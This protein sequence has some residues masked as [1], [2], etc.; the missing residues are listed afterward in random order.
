MKNIYLDSSATVPVY[1]EVIEAMLPFLTKNYGNPSS[2]HVMGEIASKAVSGARREISSELGC[3]A[4][5]IVFTSG[6][7]E[8]NC[9]AFMGLLNKSKKKK[10]VVSSIEHSSIR[11]ACY[12][13]KNEGCE[14]IEI[15]V[16]KEGFVNYK[17]LEEIIDGKTA[18]VSVIHG[19]NEIGTLQD[20][21][22]IAKICESKGAL[23]HTDAVQTFGRQKLSV[24]N[25]GIDMLSVS[26]H[27]IGGPKGIGAL[28][29]REGIKLTPIIAGEQERGLRGGTENVPGI[30]GF[31]KALQVTK[32]NN[33]N[34][35]GL[36]NNLMEGIAKIGGKIT[37][38]K[39]KRLDDHV[40]A[41]FEGLDAENLMLYLSQNGVMCST[42]SACLNKSIKENHV[43][44]AIGLSSME[45]KGAIRFGLHPGI[46]K[47]DLS[48]TL[49]LI[50]KFIKG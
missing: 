16:D 49:S 30:V 10:I 35:R 5:E 2:P 34:I 15:G 21:G 11:E 4:Q 41:Y 17:R 25:I 44:K 19:N 23:F 47:G 28:Y 12:I 29:V 33:I 3:M 39:D 9:L 22:C 48:R 38:S 6:G 36:R 7:T 45:I 18:L 37:G 8:A 40:S 13:L 24:K 42:K 20:L 27:K 26:A 46:T 14:I 43:L 1:P 32:K 50:K 31:S